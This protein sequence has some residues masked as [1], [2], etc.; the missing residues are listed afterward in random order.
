MFNLSV[1]MATGFR[2]TIFFCTAPKYFYG[3]KITKIID[4]FETQYFH[5]L[6][7]L[8]SA[9]NMYMYNIQ[10]NARNNRTFYMLQ[11]LSKSQTSLKLTLQNIWD[12]NIMV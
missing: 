5:K 4:A 1:T 3:I 10:L 8:Q 6:T 2:F 11:W 9:Y 12:R 7:Y